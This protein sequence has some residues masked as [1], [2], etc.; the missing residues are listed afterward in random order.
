[1]LVHHAARLGHG[2]FTFSIS[3]AGADIVETNTF[4]SIYRSPWLTTT[5]SRTLYELNLAGAR[6]AKRAA[7]R[8]D[9]EGSSAAVLCIAGAIGPTN[10]TCSISTDDAQRCD[11]RGQRMKSWSM[12]SYDERAA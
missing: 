11:A 7:D 12:P 10:R 6:A 5:W 1:M 9:G 4:N 8:V 3:E 2:S